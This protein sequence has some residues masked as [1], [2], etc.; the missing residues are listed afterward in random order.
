MEFLVA[1]LN[2]VWN[3]KGSSEKSKTS[4]G[5]FQKSRSSTSPPLLFEFI[6]WN[7]SMTTY[8]ALPCFSE[9][10]KKLFYTKWLIVDRLTRASWCLCEMLEDGS[11]ESNEIRTHNHLV[12]KRT[13]NHLVKLAN[14]WAV[15]WVLICTVHLTVCYYHVTYESQSEMSFISAMVLVY[16]CFHKKNL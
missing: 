11:S 4:K 6:F 2:F 14:D 5:L 8:K 7:S 10:E 9:S 3:F 12:R 1:K 13:L 15:L 16:K